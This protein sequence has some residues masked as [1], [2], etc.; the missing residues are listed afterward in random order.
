VTN[1]FSV[2]AQAAHPAI[3]AAWPRSG[4]WK[5]VQERKLQEGRSA[6]VK[7][8]S[9]SPSELGMFG[10]QP[11]RM[12]ASLRYVGGPVPR[13]DVGRARLLWNGR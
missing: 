11:R 3:V 1:G 13:A 7:R 9:Y 4:K 2:I 10:T 6:R 12:V 8:G 5:I